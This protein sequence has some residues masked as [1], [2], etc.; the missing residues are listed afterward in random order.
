MRDVEQEAQDE[1]FEGRARKEGSY[2]DIRLELG[3][4]VLLD[5]PALVFHP[6][7]VGK[8]NRIPGRPLRVAEV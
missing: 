2:P 6:K 8:K 3:P 1:L 5:H 7:Y 4:G